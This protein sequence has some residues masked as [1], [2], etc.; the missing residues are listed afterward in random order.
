VVLYFT[1]E[2]AVDQTIATG[3]ASPT[4]PANVLA[5][6]TATIDGLP[7]TVL[8]A[9]MTPGAVGLGQV[10]V[11]VPATGPDGKQLPPD[12]Y[13]V[14][15][16]VGGTKSNFG[17][18]SV[19]QY[20]AATAEY[21]VAMKMAPQYSYLPYN[22]GLPFQQFND[23]RA[24]ESM[25]KKAMKLAEPTPPGTSRPGAG[26][27]ST[28]HAEALNGL[29]TV[30]VLRH[31]YRRAGRLIQQASREDPQSLSVRHNHALLLA[32]SK[33]TQ[34]QA[35]ALWKQ[36]L[37]QDPKHLPSLIGYSDW[38][39]DHGRSAEAVP[40]YREI[41]RQRPAYTVASI[42]LAMALLD[43]GQTESA[44]EALREPL[45]R[46]RDRPELLAAQ[47]EV[48]LG[49]NRRDDAREEFVRAE[50]SATNSQE[51]KR[52]AGRRHAIGL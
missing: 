45:R 31:R 6:V 38:L 20:A 11:T 5:S 2:G 7:A 28:R 46:E 18:V 30:A 16:T 32:R 36:N 43:G 29:A 10:N 44:A 15:L 13:P 50:K 26:A 19:G 42:A 3:A 1:G 17:N 41:L 37:K 34:D 48:L 25:Y 22:L 21:Q 51:K 14:V 47:G 49:E 39:K 52:I 33:D 12:D 35:E 24:A 40:L 8:F 9:G 23:L 27:R 4:P